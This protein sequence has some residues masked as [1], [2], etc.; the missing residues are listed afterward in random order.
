M[1]ALTVPRLSGRW[2]ALVSRPVLS[3]MSSV[4]AAS[5]RRREASVSWRWSAKPRT[6]VGCWPGPS[7]RWRSGGVREAR[8]RMED[9]SPVRERRGGKATVDMRGAVQGPGVRGGEIVSR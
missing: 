7:G 6:R 4:A 8:E 1:T 3:A 9:Q 2:G 5:G